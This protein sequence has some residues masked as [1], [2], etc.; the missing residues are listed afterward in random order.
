M[1]F[2]VRIE[3]RVDPHFLQTI[4]TDDSDI[5]KTITNYNNKSVL[6]VVLQNVQ[7]VRS[8]C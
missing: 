1:D 4:F 7:L 5:N 8:K 2:N 3:Q 6:N